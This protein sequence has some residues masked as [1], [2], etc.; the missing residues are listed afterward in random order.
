MDQLTAELEAMASLVK[1]LEQLEICIGEEELLTFC[2][3]LS[4]QE[5]EKENQKKEES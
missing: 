5:R 4:S 2:R 3:E 1:E